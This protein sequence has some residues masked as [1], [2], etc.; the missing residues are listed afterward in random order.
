MADGGDRTLDRIVRQ[1][2]AAREDARRRYA[3][4]SRERLRRN[5]ET[6]IR[7]TMIGSLSLIEQ[8]FGDLWGQGKPREDLT[9][10][11]QRNSQTKDELRTEI[12]NLGNGQIR[13]AAAEIAQYDVVW[14][15]YRYDLSP[16][17]GGGEVKQEGNE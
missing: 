2:E 9:E 4:G 14:N 3:D 17:V 5:V 12:L 6:K 10:D 15:R 13:A 1:R 16:A 7:T 11:E 8:F